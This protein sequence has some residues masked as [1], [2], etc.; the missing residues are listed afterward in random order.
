MDKKVYDYWLYSLL[1]IGKKTFLKLAKEDFDGKYLYENKVMELPDFLSK[2]QKA[3]I[4]KGY[5]KTKE[6]LQRSYEKLLK[7]GIFLTVFGDADY[8][9]KLLE[10]P[11]PPAVLF[12]KG[13]LPKEEEKCI[14]I[15]GARNCSSYGRYVAE[16]FAR[17]FAAQNITVISGMANGID[18]YAQSAAVSEGGFSVGVLGCGVE[19]CYP[20]EN[21]ELYQNLI[22]KGCVLS[23]YL[24]YD[25]PTANLF[26]PRNRIISGLCDALIVVEAREKSGTLITVEMALEQGKEVF[27][28]PG[29][30]TD[31]LSHGCNKLLLE[32]AN[33][34]LSPMQVVRSLYGMEAKEMMKEGREKERE[35]ISDIQKQILSF[36]EINPL[37]INVLQDRTGLPMEVLSREL[38]FMNMEGYV[39]QTGSGWYQ[40]KAEQL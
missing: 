27:V 4:I 38:L 7:A 9:K 19:E 1:G 25:K 8:P 2:R 22:K 28:V 17:Y 10:I 23:E 32:G 33:P 3:S 37:H 11:D 20:L 35:R 13:R 24:P 39:V 26:P 16:K 34:A 30:I 14:A 18:G 31:S 15:I 40:R 6:H 36:L 21:K 29:R 5:E 12:Y